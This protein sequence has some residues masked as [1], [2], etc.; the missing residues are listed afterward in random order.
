MF[1]T[2]LKQLRERDGLSQVKLAALLG[3]SQS[4]VGMWESGRNKPTFA[5]LGKIAQVFSVPVGTLL[6]ENAPAALASEAAGYATGLAVTMPDD[7]MAPDILRGDLLSLRAIT[8]VNRGDIVVFSKD[9][10][11]CVRHITLNGETVA[12]TA[13]NIELPPVVFQ[14]GKEKDAGIQL[15]G[16]VVGLQRRYH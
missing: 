7:S 5:M 1:Q 4:T 10:H 16:K 14:R 8:A 9:G 15:M 12:A 3:V 13:R 11:V 2:K 6:E